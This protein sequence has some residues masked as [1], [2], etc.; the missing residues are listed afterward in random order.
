MQRAAAHAA[1]AVMFAAGP[2]ELV[3]VSVQL[4]GPWIHE[5]IGR[6]ME[7]E[8]GERRAATDRVMADPSSIHSAIIFPA[9]P[10]AAMP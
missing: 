10:P 7:G 3:M 5:V 9:P 8:T 6:V 1:G 4:D 2:R